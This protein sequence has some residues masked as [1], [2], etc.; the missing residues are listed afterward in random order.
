MQRMSWEKLLSA[1]RLDAKTYDPDENYDLRSE[2][3]KDV[4]R[5]IFS[6]AFRRLQDKTQVM[7]MPDSDYV[8][9]RLTHSIEVASVARSLGKLAGNFIIKQESL[10]T[11]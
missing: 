9:S 10:N 11:N 7:P 6:S 5:I 8:R 2:F 1:K 3:Q 4:D